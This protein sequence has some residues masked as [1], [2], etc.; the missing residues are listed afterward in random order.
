M[1]EKLFRIKE[2]QREKFFRHLTPTH[3]GINIGEAIKNEI[4]SFNDQINLSRNKEAK[5][6]VLNANIDDS[7]INEQIKKG[8]FPVR[9]LRSLIA[10]FFLERTKGTDHCQKHTISDFEHFFHCFERVPT[11]GLNDND[12]KRCN[13][14]IKELQNSQYVN[15]FSEYEIEINKEDWTLL[16]MKDD[17]PISF[18]D[19][20]KGQ[21]DAKQLPED[22]SRSLVDAESAQSKPLY[23]RFWPLIAIIALGL[24][25]YGIYEY[26]Q[27][28]KLQEEFA[29]K[30]L[31]IENAKMIRESNVNQLVEVYNE[32]SKELNGD[33]GK[34]GIRNISNELYGRIIS[35]SEGLLPYL[36]FKNDTLIDR[37]LSPERA[38]LFVT[39]FRSKLDQATFLKVISNANFSYSDFSSYDLNDLNLIGSVSGIVK[40]GGI[41]DSN[42]WITTAKR[43]N[44]RYSNFDGVSL[45]STVLFGD[46]SFCTFRNAIF[47][48]AYFKW[49][50]LQESNFEGST[51][52]NCI[53][54]KS[55]IRHSNFKNSLFKKEFAAFMSCDLRGAKFNGS[56][57][58]KNLTYATFDNCFFSSQVT[59]FD[60]SVNIQRE[61]ITLIADPFMYNSDSTSS[62]IKST[63]HYRSEY[64]LAPKTNSTFYDA[65]TISDFRLNPNYR[66]LGDEEQKESLFS[67]LIGINYSGDPTTG[68]FSYLVRTSDN[69]KLGDFIY[70]EE[71]EFKNQNEQMA[72]DTLFLKQ[73]FPIYRSKP[74]KI[75]IIYPD[76]ITSLE[77]DDNS[78]LN[79]VASFANCTFQGI[80]FRDSNMAYVSFKGST[81]ESAKSYYPNTFN[82]VRF[83]G[84]DF[85]VEKGELNFE[86]N[87][88]FHDLIVNDA[89]PSEYKYN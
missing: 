56:V 22:E 81:F 67:K 2:G 48:S 18:I 4:S 88:T 24:L 86:G 9:T 51:F 75:E 89:F 5:P 69:N 23:V 80:I 15:T 25:G 47:N 57:F 11:T 62:G 35:L 3:K 37:K 44:F 79:G 73:S 85:R 36:Y 38:D 58:S 46:F 32:I 19:S 65:N 39:L 17:Q 49:S 16:I 33:Y 13:N 83:K 87:T 74:D 26:T 28:I 27:Y 50:E 10:Y 84:N 60:Y 68:V 43:G 82:N 61:G 6:Y 70:V 30:N 1:G 14:L 78:Q 21:I 29:K 52:N 8:R 64:I 66:F 71:S 54:E 53:F 40:E 55:S 59:F 45:K 34:D 72:G 77:P 12:F 31:I 76:G 20:N 7:K 63:R 42:L 41:Y